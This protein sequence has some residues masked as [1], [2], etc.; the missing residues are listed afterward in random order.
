MGCEGKTTL[1]MRFVGADCWGGV[2]STSIGASNCINHVK[3]AAL[4]SNVNSVVPESSPL[5]MLVRVSVV[6]EEA[7]SFLGRG[8]SD[9]GWFI[10]L[11]T[12]LAVLEMPD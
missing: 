10:M 3:D 12:D 8:V 9:E 2:K 4:P 1:R 7:A 6:E 5:L 11:V